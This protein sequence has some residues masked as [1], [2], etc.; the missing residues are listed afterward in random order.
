MLQSQ[1]GRNLLGSNIDA[2]LN[3]PPFDPL[4]AGGSS[5]TPSPSPGPSPAVGGGAGGGLLNVRVNRVHQAEEGKQEEARNEQQAQPLE[6]SDAAAL[7]MGL[8]GDLQLDDRRRPKKIEEDEILRLI[9]ESQEA[10]EWSESQSM[11]DSSQTDTF[12]ARPRAAAGLGA[13]ALGKRDPADGAPGLEGNHQA[14][15]GG[16]ILAGGAS[17]TPGKHQATPSLVFGDGGEIYDQPKKAVYGIK[18]ATG[19]AF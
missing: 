13:G 5:L 8:D 15:P 14:F 16:Q 11:Y 12:H 6:H 9:H 2:Q 17:K 19:N 1:S 10:Q 18:K 4:T 7:Q 3:L